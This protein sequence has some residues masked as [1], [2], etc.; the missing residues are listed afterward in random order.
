MTHTALDNTIVPSFAIP[1][2]DGSALTACYWFDTHADELKR[3][4]LAR[5]EE[6]SLQPSGE[7]YAAWC[8]KRYDRYVEATFAVFLRISGT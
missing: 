7:S 8:F 5:T 6:R 1:A 3:V 2:A 4:Y